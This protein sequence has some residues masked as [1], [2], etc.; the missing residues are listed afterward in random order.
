MLH[1]W[2]PSEYGKPHEWNQAEVN[3]NAD[4]DALVEQMRKQ[5][6]KEPKQYASA[7]V[8]AV[9]KT[10]YNDV[11]RSIEEAEED[12]TRTYVLAMFYRS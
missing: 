1:S 10:Y 12:Q 2:L 7:F 4:V 6:S 9:R 8:E 3:L 5:S 11:R